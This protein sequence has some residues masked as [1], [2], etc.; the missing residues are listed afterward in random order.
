[1]EESKDGIFRSE[2]E[3][4]MTAIAALLHAV[5]HIMAMEAEVVNEAEGQQGEG[6]GGEELM[7]RCPWLGLVLSEFIAEHE[8]VLNL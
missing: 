2:E 8:R 4:N 7:F 6:Q 1:M 5:G 3:K